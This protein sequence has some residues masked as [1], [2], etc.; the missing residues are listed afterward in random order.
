[1]A[2]EPQHQGRGSWGLGAGVLMGILGTILLL[3]LIV[4][5]SF[6]VVGRCPLC[7]RMMRDGMMRDGMM[8]GRMMGEDQAPGWM[9]SRQVMHPDMMR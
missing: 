2:Q 7:G 1:M 6:L 4:A 3:L 8:N 9:M 5:V